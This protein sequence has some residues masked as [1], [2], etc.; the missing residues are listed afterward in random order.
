MQ[1]LVLADAASK[2]ELLSRGCA[3]NVEVT[4]IGSVREV[5]D[6]PQAHA[7][8]DLMFELNEERLAVLNSFLPRPVLINSVSIP[9]SAA[10]SSFV[11]INGWPGFLKAERVEAA[12]NEENRAE[13]N[14]VMA[15]FH[16]RLE[17]LPDTIG[18][19]TPR[20]I[21]MII[22]EA[23]L[24]LGEGVSTKQAIDTAMK[25][26]TNYPFGPF[27]WAGHIG[28]SN[29]LTLLRALH[30]DNPRYEPA[31]LLVEEASSKALTA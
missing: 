24:S 10:G 14:A 1:I 16:R 6:H 27:E 21:S 13:A 2:E 20:V 23:Y 3:D 11:R 26:G 30:L 12:G 15:C 18:F 31:A 4:W 9:L 5:A 8:I 17:W 29:L 28:L 7:L 22:N 25:L 19:V